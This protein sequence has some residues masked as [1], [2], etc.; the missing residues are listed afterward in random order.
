MSGQILLELFRM[1]KSKFARI[2]RLLNVLKKAER[3]DV[4]AQ[5]AAL[6]LL[7]GMGWVQEASAAGLTPEQLVQ[8]LGTKLSAE[9]Q[10]ALIGDVQQVLASPELSQASADA[11]AAK[12]APLAAEAGVSED[13]LMSML[14]DAGFS[15]TQLAQLKPELEDEFIQ[16][17]L[18]TPAAIQSASAENLTP[19]DPTNPAL[20]QGEGVI[21]AAFSLGSAIGAGTAAGVVA[22]AGLGGGG[23]A[24]ASTDTGTS[25]TTDITITEQQAADLIASNQPFAASDNVTLQVDGTTVSDKGLNLVGLQ[26]LG[27]DFI[28]PDSTTDGSINIALGNVSIDG[29][30]STVAPQF[31]DSA[32]ATLGLSAAGTEFGSTS[33]LA[34]LHALGVDA[35][36]LVDGGT[37]GIST[38]E[39]VNVLDSGLVFSED[40]VTF[41]SG[42]E[43][44]TNT[45][46]VLHSAGTSLMDTPLTIKSLSLLGVDS[47]DTTAASDKL[48]VALGADN[49][50]EF[51]GHEVPSFVNHVDA[52]VAINDEFIAS[53][54]SKQ[55]AAQFF[56][57]LN[58]DHASIVV[59]TSSAELDDVLANLENL[60][61]G[62]TPLADLNPTQ[63][64]DALNN[65]GVSEIV[66]D[67]HN[68]L[69]DLPGDARLN[70]LADAGLL[71]AETSQTLEQVAD[72]ATNAQQAAAV[73]TLDVDNVRLVID[74][75]VDFSG[76]AAAD[77]QALNDLLAKFDDN[78]D[79]VVESSEHLFA[80][81]A[82]VTL[83]V[84]TSNLA[85]TADQ[86][87]DLINLGVDSLVNSDG[88]TVEIIG[89]TGDQPDIFQH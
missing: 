87:H 58:A 54:S 55:A 15:D 51:T 60:N 75:G 23:A 29:F 86:L 6:G 85:L 22:G 45:E 41:S 52:T 4:L 72:L 19:G 24:A 16:A 59:G 63:L 62:S 33:K 49:V 35:L 30:D 32:D 67:T 47:L 80:Q 64:V 79:G 12:L 31:T 9:Q 3:H 69:D 27:V 57:G 73:D 88:V 89:K 18:N 61:E 7:F 43:T 36:A 82:K 68:P 84:D 66:F 37:L 65:A 42:Q 13:E 25:T 78:T 1:T 74:S 5:A 11:L 34:G 28:V 50:S 10:Q 77:A 17:R 81:G 48:T 53:F 83:A 40:F 70:A 8:K 2:Q 71:R 56:D 39:A 38:A 76:N 21:P 46:V 20:A 26:A 44:T 14:K